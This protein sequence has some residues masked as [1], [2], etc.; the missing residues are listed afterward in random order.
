MACGLNASPGLQWL[1]LPGSSLPFQA[2]LVLCCTQSQLLPNMAVHFPEAILCSLFLEFFP[3]LSSLLPLFCLC[4]SFF[5]SHVPFLK[6]LQLTEMAP[7]ATQFCR[8]G[9]GGCAEE[10]E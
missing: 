1:P 2:Y 6:P 4:I 8:P 10:E 3:D 7:S 5:F 9:M